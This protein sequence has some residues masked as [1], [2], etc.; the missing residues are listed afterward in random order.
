MVGADLYT[1][2]RVEMFENILS[3]ICDV[4]VNWDAVSAIATFFATV[5]AFFFSLLALRAPGR[6]RSE[7]RSEF[8]SEILSATE[9]AIN[10][11]HTAKKISDPRDEAWELVA[12]RARHT[13]VALQILLQ[14]PSLTDG[15]I[16]TGAGALTLLEAVILQHESNK[17]PPP[18]NGFARR[19]SNELSLATPIVDQVEKRAKEVADYA[20]KRKYPKWKKR[21]RGIRDNGLMGSSN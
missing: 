13:R 14:R 20:C 16:T 9:T 5:T 7:D 2:T 3:E 17:S 11:F 6:A 10:I 15:G 1:N 19:V 8:T 12:A 18:S 4:T 21:F